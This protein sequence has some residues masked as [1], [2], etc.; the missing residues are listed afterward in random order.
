MKISP[1]EDWECNLVIECLQRMHKAL[2]SSTRTALPWP[3]QANRYHPKILSPLNYSCTCLI[4]CV[5]NLGKSIT[6]PMFLLVALSLASAELSSSYSIWC[7]LSFFQMELT[8]NGTQ[9]FTS[10]SL[11]ATCTKFFSGEHTLQNGYVQWLAT[12]ECE[13]VY[14]NFWHLCSWKSVSLLSP[15]LHISAVFTV[16]TPLP[17][18][19]LTLWL[20]VPQSPFLP[21]IIINDSIV[22][23]MITG[24]TS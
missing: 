3:K 9:T 24:T 21:K 5:M 2:G 19:P 6:G 14:F 15:H 17:L 16:W 1:E 7:L 11:K 22:L 20:P 12:Y 13:S 8:Q 23:K 10:L 4:P 18:I